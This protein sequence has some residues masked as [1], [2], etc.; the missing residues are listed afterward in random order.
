MS[1]LNLYI[2]N[3]YEATEENFLQKYLVLVKQ[4]LVAKRG[5]IELICIYDLL[6]AEQQTLTQQCFDLQESF[7]L[8]LKDVS[9]Y[10]RILVAQ[11]I[12]ILWA[13]GS[14]FEQFNVYVSIFYKKILNELVLMFNY[15]SE[16]SIFLDQRCPELIITTSNRTSSW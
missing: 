16:K 5:N 11:S 4:I 15:L 8:A 1:K 3:N 6:N 12:G 7:A 9:E 10:T 13:I 14:S 2:K